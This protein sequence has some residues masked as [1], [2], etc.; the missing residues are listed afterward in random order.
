MDIRAGADD[1]NLRITRHSR[2]RL[3]W[4]GKGRRLR[5]FQRKVGQGS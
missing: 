4:M 3:A 1:P 5:P 2:Q